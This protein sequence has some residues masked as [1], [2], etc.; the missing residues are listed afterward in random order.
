MDFGRKEAVNVLVRC[1]LNSSPEQIQREV[2]NF[3]KHDKISAD[4]LRKVLA[5]LAGI[6]DFDAQKVIALIAVEGS[7]FAS[8]FSSMLDE[9]VLDARFNSQAVQKFN[10]II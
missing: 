7:V 10:Q 4:D 6:S 5:Q 3:A 1:V 8:R 9:A 2:S